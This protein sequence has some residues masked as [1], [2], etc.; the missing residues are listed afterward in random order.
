MARQKIRKS[1]RAAKGQS[2]VTSAGV[3][4][5]EVPDAPCPYTE[6]LDG[7]HGPAEDILPAVDQIPIPA[8]LL[9]LPVLHEHRQVP[10]YDIQ[11]GFGHFIS[12]SAEHFPSP[13]AGSPA[14][15]KATAPIC[16]GL[17][18]SASAR[19]T[20]AR[21]GS[22]LFRLKDREFANRLGCGRR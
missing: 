6:W 16:P 11:I 22:S 7:R 2:D 4:W 21:V 19:M 18:D 20:T 9:S 1:I 15:L 17:R 10:N 8:V 12:S 13:V 14:R 3:P 5:S